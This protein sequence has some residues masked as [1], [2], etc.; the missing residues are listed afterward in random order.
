MAVRRA[1]ELVLTEAERS[2]LAGL[3]ARRSTAQVLAL[4]AR[5]VL[6]CAAG[7]SNRD[8]ANKLGQHTVGK[9]RRRFAEQRIE[10]LRD[11]A[12]PGAPR[13]VG[14]ER[15]EALVTAT[16]ESVPNNATHWV[17][18]AWRGRAACR[19][20]PCSVSGAHSACSR[21][22][23]KRSSCPATLTSWPSPLGD[24]TAKQPVA[25][26]PEECATSLAFI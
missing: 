8:V 2:E 10:G 19:C 1:V 18:V 3:A 21:I 11:E 6:A 17:C 4:R 5:I 26:P 7:T 13:T 12:R 14:D 23:W 24:P 15:I 25:E 20:P 16:L 9:S 22:V